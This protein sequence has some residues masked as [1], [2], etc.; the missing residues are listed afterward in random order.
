MWSWGSR[1][2]A[3]LSEYNI[4]DIW[5]TS[6]SWWVGKR[7]AVKSW[8]RCEATIPRA[9]QKYTQIKTSPFQRK[10]LSTVLPN[11]CKLEREGQLE[12]SPNVKLC[13]PAEQ[14]Y[15][16]TTTSPFQRKWQFSLKLRAFPVFIQ[17][18]HFCHEFCHEISEIFTDFFFKDLCIYKRYHNFFGSIPAA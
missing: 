17:I 16:Q 4:F 6:R 18:L 13:P 10:L 3:F 9:K 5:F 1:I 15:T 11:P 2:N 7:A 8:S 14:N 12:V